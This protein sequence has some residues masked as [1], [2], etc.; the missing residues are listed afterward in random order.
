VLSGVLLSLG[1]ACCYATTNVCLARAGLVRSVLVIPATL[2]WNVLLLGIAVLWK[3]GTDFGLSSVPVSALLLYA[4]VGLLAGLLGRSGLFFTIGR[5][6]PSRASTVVNAAPR[7]SLPLGLVLFGQVPTM[8]GVV[9][10]VLIVLSVWILSRDR[11]SV[12]AALVG[13]R[14]D[15][16][17]PDHDAGA[18]PPRR[19]DSH[20]LQGM[21]MGLVVALVFG[22]SDSVRL[23]A[24][25][26]ADDPLLA[27]WVGSVCAL[28]LSLGWLFSR[29][30]GRGLVPGVGRAAA[31]PWVAGAG[32]ATSLAMMANLAAV[33]HLY[34]GYVTALLAV[35]PVV[36]L[37]LTK[38]VSP[39]SESLGRHGN[40]AMAAVLTGTVL[41]ALGR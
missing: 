17:R 22:A 15:G 12:P 36:T 19:R 18:A 2:L 30:H 27:A 39:G 40:A 1:A 35:S 38:I 14:A 23:F 29:G 25:Q 37:V 32:A 5:I 11:A 4:A 6:G 16:E 31:G 9:G 26:V 33:G 13:T 28:V 20:H 34:V 10:V 21:A 8:A 24:I 7:F 41:V 3:H